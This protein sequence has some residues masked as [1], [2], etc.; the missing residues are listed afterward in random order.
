MNIP[1]G[2]DRAACAR[3]TPREADRTFFEGSTTDQMRTV[4][5]WCQPCPIR[6]VCLTYAMDQQTEYGVAGATTGAER[7]RLRAALPD[8]AH[9]GPLLSRAGA[10]EWALPSLVENTHILEPLQAWHQA[11]QDERTSTPHV[12]ALVKEAREQWEDLALL[13]RLRLLATWPHQASTP[14]PPTPTEV[15]YAGA[16]T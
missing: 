9:W 1:S 15:A 12:P 7:A 11:Q 10:W 4:W 2:Q 6:T 13:T 14:T 5:V 8:I 3:L 16:P